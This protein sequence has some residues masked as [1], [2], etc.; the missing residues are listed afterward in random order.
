MLH[1]GAL[2]PFNR[3]QRAQR[4]LLRLG[5]SPNTVDIE[6]LVES[7]SQCLQRLATLEV[8]EPDGPVIPATGQPAAIGTHLERLHRALVRLSHPHTLATLHLPPAQPA[9][10]AST[11]HHLPTGNPAQHRDHSR[12]PFKGMH[13]LP[14]V[15]IPYE[16]LSA[17]SPAATR[18]QPPPI[19][20]PGHTH[21][22]SLMSRQLPLQRASG[23]LPHI[24]TEEVADRLR[25]DLDGK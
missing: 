10:T 15:H 2:P 11:D 5:Q 13:A 6:A 20:A 3:P 4:R 24:A 21:H 16:Q 7:I 17:L 9:V 23:R 25:H 18:G 19:G 12:M 22:G 14:T 1:L 8:P